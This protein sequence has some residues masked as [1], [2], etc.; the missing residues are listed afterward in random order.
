MGITL[1]IDGNQN[2]V[3]RNYLSHLSYDGS[4]QTV[5]EL[6]ENHVDL[7]NIMSSSERFIDC[8]ETYVKE[9]KVALNAAK[10]CFAYGVSG[11]IDL[12]NT[13]GD[14]IAKLDKNHLLHIENIHAND[15]IIKGHD[16]IIVYLSE[17]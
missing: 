13:E 4:S 16:M 7:F 8:I 6:I 5:G 17:K 12:V 15:L 3:L 14:L 10:H 11:K 1:T 2:K 9:E